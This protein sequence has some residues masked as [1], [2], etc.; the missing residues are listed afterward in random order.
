MEKNYH[1]NFIG[2]LNTNSVYYYYKHWLKRNGGEIH[3]EQNENRIVEM[4]V[5]L[6]GIFFSQNDAQFMVQINRILRHQF[7]LHSIR[8]LSNFHA[9]LNKYL[10][11]I[12]WF[13]NG[14]MDFEKRSKYYRFSMKTV[15]T[16]HNSRKIDD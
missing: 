4:M 12:A 14:K 11:E 3:S 10:T 16:M 2:I 9:W 1:I 15:V 5:M 8:I 7:S 13:F 6:R